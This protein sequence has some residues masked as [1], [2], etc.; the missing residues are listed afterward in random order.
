[1]AIQ[2]VNLQPEARK[3]VIDQLDDM[4]LRPATSNERGWFALVEFCNEPVTIWATD[5]CLPDVAGV[6]E[7]DDL[8]PRN[9]SFDL[10]V[11]S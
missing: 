3:H 5:E 7:I 8:F 4:G 6:N 9:V 11:R 2:F 1:M 10:S